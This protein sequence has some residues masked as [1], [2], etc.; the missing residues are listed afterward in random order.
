MVSA[1]YKEMIEEHNREADEPSKQWRNW[2]NI[3]API[4]LNVRGAPMGRREPGLHMSEQLWPS[5]ER[6]EEVAAKAARENPESYS[7]LDYI[8]A[9]PDG[10]D[11][12]TAHSNHRT[13]SGEKP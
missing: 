2:W 4:N 8:G 3:L 13:S 1:D 10:V 9:F 5:K 12:A 6:A 11:P 7:R